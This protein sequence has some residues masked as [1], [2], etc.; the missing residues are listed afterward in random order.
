LLFRL[1]GGLLVLQPQ[2]G[3]SQPGPRLWAAIVGRCARAARVGLRA[4]ASAARGWAASCGPTEGRRLSFLSRKFDISS[5][6]NSEQIFG[7]L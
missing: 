1:R 7:G 3:Q 2:A 4:R 5:K 6:L